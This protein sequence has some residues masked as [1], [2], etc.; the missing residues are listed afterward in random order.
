MTASG[1]DSHSKIIP[2]RACG[3]SMQGGQL[4]NAMYLDMRVP[5]SAGGP[6]STLDDLLQWNKALHA[7]GFLGKPTYERMIAPNPET[8]GENVIFGYGIFITQRL[9]HT[10]LSHTGAVNGFLSALQYYPVL[11][12]SLIV[13]SN[14]VDLARFMP[15]IER[16]SELFLQ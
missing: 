11:R 13:L 4:Q 6:Y 1:Y 15:M 9:G 3:Y 14:F 5:Y 7:G 8:S 10:C 16:L 2:G 12:A